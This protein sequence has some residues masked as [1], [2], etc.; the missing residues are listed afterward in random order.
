MCMTSALQHGLN[1]LHIMRSP[2]SSREHDD[3]ISLAARVQAWRREG[4]Y[5]AAGRVAI[6]ASAR[7]VCDPR[8]EFG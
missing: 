5:Q 8:Q 1:R 7:A 3:G 6:G 4:G 2:H